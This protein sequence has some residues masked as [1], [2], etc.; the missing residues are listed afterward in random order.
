[1]SNTSK[2]FA[3]LVIAAA[4]TI[5]AAPPA[6]AGIIGSDHNICSQSQSVQFESGGYLLAYNF[7]PR[8]A[9]LLLRAG[10]LR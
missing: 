3:V 7:S 5:A 8:L 2:I 4:L 10:F 9:N 6:S 1:M